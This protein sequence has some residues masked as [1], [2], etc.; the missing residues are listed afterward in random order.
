MHYPRSRVY[1]TLL[2]LLY[3]FPLVQCSPYSP[4]P[5]LFP[6][7]PASLHAPREPMH[8]CMLP[9]SL[10]H[11]ICASPAGVTTTIL[12]SKTRLRRGLYAR[13]SCAC[14]ATA[15]RTDESSAANHARP[16]RLYLS[17]YRVVTSLSVPSIAVKRTVTF[18]ARTE[19]VFSIDRRVKPRKLPRISIYQV[20]CPIT[21]SARPERDR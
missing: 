4:P 2:L 19:H 1:A 10:S 13:A 11:Y 7:S 5:S 17:L 12:S 21:R 9:P 16:S 3:S 6:S 20:A 18:R 14:I 8:A 15:R